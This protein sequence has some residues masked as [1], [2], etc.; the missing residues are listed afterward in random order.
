MKRIS[1][2]VFGSLIACSLAVPAAAQERSAASYNRELSFGYSMLRDIG[3]T[4]SFGTLV[5]FGK[6]IG[7]SPV[8]IIGEVAFNKFGGDYDETYQ[9]YGGGIRLGKMAGGKTRLFA[10]MVVAGQRSLG[11][12]G[13]AYQPGIG[14]NLRLARS[15]DLKVQTDFPIVQWEGDTYKQFRLN[16][17]FG[18]PLGGK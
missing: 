17:G 16:I 10:Q 18:V 12:T 3:E 1:L 13:V 7:S 6:K 14:F 8:S 11:V 5:D 2:V 9:Q 4:S 15:L